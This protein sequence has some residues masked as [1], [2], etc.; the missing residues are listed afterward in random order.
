MAGNYR[1]DKLLID[2]FSMMWLAV[3]LSGQIGHEQLPSWEV[4][5]DRDSIGA[6]ERQLQCVA[7]A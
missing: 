2:V 3:A 7:H 4:L 1:R 6:P 5:W